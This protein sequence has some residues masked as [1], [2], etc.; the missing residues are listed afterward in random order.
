MRLGLVVAIM[1]ATSAA[2]AGAQTD[3]AAQQTRLAEASPAAVASPEAFALAKL[4]SP[5][6]LRIETELREFDLNFR[7]ALLQQPDVQKV[8]ADYPGV[9]DAMAK[10]ARPV[11]A[12]QAGRVADRTY[13]AVAKLLATEFT[14]NDIA[15]LT[16][17]Y[18]SPAGQRL[19]RH[20]MESVDTSGQYAAAA[21]GKNVGTEEDASAQAFIASMKAMGQL[22]EADWQELKKLSQRPAF[23][24]LHALQPRLSKL[25]QDSANA[26][27]PDY[28]KRIE[29]VMGAAV[30]G[31][32]K[33]HQA[34]AGKDA[35]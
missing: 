29:D 22:S 4:M 13:P 15:E 9:V 5:R 20:V 18:G 33:A 11:I 21:Q 30:S 8:E 1:A 6:D 16:A 24:K 14:P 17:Y 3:R 2:S 12:E 31:H 23:V 28:D 25:V 7:K 34:N 35:K 32:I 26:P 19:L 10:E 27:D